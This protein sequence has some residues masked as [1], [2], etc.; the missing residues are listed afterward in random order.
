MKHKRKQTKVQAEE[1]LMRLQKKK[2]KM[3]HEEIPPPYVIREN[4][5]QV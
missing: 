3:L 1:E 2:N 5:A 4:A